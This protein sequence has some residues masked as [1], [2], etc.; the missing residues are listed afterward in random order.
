MY[1]CT[2]NNYTGLLSIHLKT[3]HLG[4]LDED[5]VPGA[6]V[7]AS[8]SLD[9]EVGHPGGEDHPRA[10][11]GLAPPHEGV[12]DAVD[13]LDGPDDEDADE[14]FV[15]AGSVDDHEPPE[16]PVEQVCAV[17]HLAQTPECRYSYK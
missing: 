16:C 8:G 10:H 3:C 13:E 11:Q 9:D 14:D 15:E 6:E 5:P 17:E 7:E 12:E 2:H 4:Y 1:S